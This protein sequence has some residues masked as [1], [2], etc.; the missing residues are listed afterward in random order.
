MPEPEVMITPEKIH[1]IQAKVNTVDPEISE[2]MIWAM[3]SCGV[4]TPHIHWIMS[5]SAEDVA[6]WL[7][8]LYYPQEVAG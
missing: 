6:D 5:T 7:I 8:G 1:A 2:K 4:N 3:L